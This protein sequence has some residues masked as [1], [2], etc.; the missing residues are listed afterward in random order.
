MK[1]I[2]VVLTILCFASLAHAYCSADDV[3]C[4]DP[5]TFPGCTFFY[6]LDNRIANFEF[7]VAEYFPAQAATNVLLDVTVRLQFTDAIPS[8]QGFQKYFYLLNQVKGTMKEIPAT[9]IKVVNEYTLDF[10]MADCVG[11]VLEPSTVY[12]FYISQRINNNLIQT[13]SSIKGINVSEK[14][15]GLAYNSL[16][17]TTTTGIFFRISL[18]DI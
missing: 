9:C 8:A 10:P 11:D 4:E 18:F 6:M 17:F 14:V 1:G 5:I 15:F 13:L 16:V 3:N 7:Y 12:V 2:N